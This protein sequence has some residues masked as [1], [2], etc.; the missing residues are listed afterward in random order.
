MKKYDYGLFTLVFIAGLGVTLQHLYH[1]MHTTP[2]V[3][4]TQY[5]VACLPSECVKAQVDQELLPNAHINHASEH[6]GKKYTCYFSFKQSPPLCQP[7]S[8][9]NTLKNSYIYPSIVEGNTCFFPDDTHKAV[10][11]MLESSTKLD[12]FGGVIAHDWNEAKELLKD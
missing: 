9:S 6:Q 5:K 10:L 3:T 1:Y 11:K 8:T 12:D 7:T 4:N 2:L